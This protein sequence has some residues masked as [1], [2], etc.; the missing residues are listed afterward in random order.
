MLLPITDE[1]VVGK[2]PSESLAPYL[3]VDGHGLPSIRSLHSLVGLEA[4]VAEASKSTGHVDGEYMSS[5]AGK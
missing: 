3:G 5:F 4:T 2:E 1:V